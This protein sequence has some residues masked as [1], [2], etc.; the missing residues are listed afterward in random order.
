[1]ARYLIPVVLFLVMIPVFIVGLGRN[2]NEIPS[3]LLDQPAP[4][5]ALPSLADPNRLVGS[6]T[7]AGQVALVNV[8]ATWCVGCRAEHDFLMELSRTS[9]VPIFGL[10]WRDQRTPALQWLADLGNPYMA[11]AF[12]GDGRVGIDWGVY[13]APET[14]LIDSDG[15]VVYK[16]IA[17]LTPDVWRTEFE[18]RIRQL[19]GEST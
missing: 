16:H 9:D 14:F 2:K 6:E 12:D 4:R 11:T 15:T 17:P 1:M 19:K 7:Y 18:P 3:P 10:N 8:W 13:G 5:Y